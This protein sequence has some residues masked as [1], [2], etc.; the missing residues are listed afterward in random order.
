MCIMIPPE[1]P[2]LVYLLVPFRFLLQHECLGLFDHIQ[3]VQSVLH[4]VHYEKRVF[5]F[6]ESTVRPHEVNYVHSRQRRVFYICEV[7]LQ[8]Q[9]FYLMVNKIDH[10]VD[11]GKKDQV[12]LVSPF[13]FVDV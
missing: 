6:F 10:P 12:P 7:N 5:V 13:A 11:C 3:D 9:G 1:T 8:H 2:N 4:I